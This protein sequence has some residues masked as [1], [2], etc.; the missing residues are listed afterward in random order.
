MN[1]PQE[2]QN[3]IES[4]LVSHPASE[5]WVVFD[6]YHTLVH[7]RH[8][9]THFHNMREKYKDIFKSIFKPLTLRQSEVALNM[10]L[11]HEKGLILINPAFPKLIH[12]LQEKKIVTFCLTTAFARSISK[13][14]NPNQWTYTYFKNTLKMDFNK[15]P[16]FAEDQKK[17]VLDCKDPVF[18][19]RGILFTNGEHGLT[20]GET[21]VLALKESPFKPKVLVMVDDTEK[22]LLSIQEELKKHDSTLTF[23]GIL[24][25]GAIEVSS[26]CTETEFK[27]F[28]QGKVDHSKIFS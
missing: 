11:E 21:I 15:R 9:A 26:S 10:A 5:M 24:F 14:Q 25:T 4:L 20:K 23:V 22:N 28:W 17:L 1:S 19:D 6:I 27:T 16:P 2:I 3:Q 12:V 8:P 18:Y 13:I 7:P